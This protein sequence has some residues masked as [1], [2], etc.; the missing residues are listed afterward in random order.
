MTRDRTRENEKEPTVNQGCGHYWVIEAAHGPTSRGVC[1]FCGAVKEFRNSWF[2]LMRSKRTE[3]DI[4]KPG[5]SLDDQSS[6]EFKELESE[7]VASVPGDN[8]A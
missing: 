3:A 4:P 7:E 2:D 6:E 5:E 1:K 8:T